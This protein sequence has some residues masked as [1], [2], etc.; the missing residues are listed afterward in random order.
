M[1]KATLYRFLRKHV[2]KY[3][4]ITKKMFLLIFTKTTGLDRKNKIYQEI[5]EMNF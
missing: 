1:Y 2:Y 3:K 4:Y 5:G